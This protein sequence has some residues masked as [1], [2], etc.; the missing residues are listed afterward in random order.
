MPYCSPHHV[1]SA[2]P[3][4]SSWL[5][6]NCFCPLTSILH[7]KAICK[8]EDA[9]AC[10]KPYHRVYPGSRV[11]KTPHFQYKGVWINKRK[12]NKI[13]FKKKIKRNIIFLKTL[14][15]PWLYLKYNL[16]SFCWSAEPWLSLVPFCPSMLSLLNSFPFLEDARSVA[17]V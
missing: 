15:Y 16:N 17:T 4:P 9:T 13:I 8:P 3:W 5:I 11:I 6:F 12:N 10:L 14:Q 2:S 7:A 1:I